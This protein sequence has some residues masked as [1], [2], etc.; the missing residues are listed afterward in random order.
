VDTNDPTG[1]GVNFWSIMAALAGSLLSFRML[2]DASPVARGISVAS[3]FLLAFFMGPAIAEWTG[4]VSPKAERA[5][6]LIVAFAGVNIMAGSWVLFV[7]WRE[8]PQEALAWLM[9]MLPTMRK[10]P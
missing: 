2:V 4:L 7:K 10:G 9:S 8:N 6:M 1:S 5:V 3:S